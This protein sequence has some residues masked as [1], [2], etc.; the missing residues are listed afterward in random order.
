MS[1]VEEFGHNIPPDDWNGE[2]KRN[3]NSR[4]NQYKTY[5]HY[6]K[7]IAKELTK[8]VE[9]LIHTTD[10]AYLFQFKEGKCWFPI[11]QITY[12]ENSKKITIPEWLWINRKY[13][14]EN[15]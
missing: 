3:S 10:K 5:S 4:R 2:Y 15:G 12:S 6:A 11:S 13:I 8:P 1:F 7:G 14:Q 9:A